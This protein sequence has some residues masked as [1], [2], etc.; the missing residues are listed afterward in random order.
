MQKKMIT[1]KNVKNLSGKVVTHYVPSKFEHTLDAQGTLTLLPA[2]IDPHVHFRTP[3]AEHKEDWMTAAKAAIHGGVTT[4]IDMPN[5]IPA[6]TTY[7]R[8]YE[9]K[10]R[11]ASQ[12]EQVKIPLRHYLYFGVDRNCL[13]EISRTK[14]EIIGLKIFMGSSTGE[15]LLDD[16]ISLEKAFAEAAK[17]NLLVAV[18]AEDEETLKKMKDRHPKATDPSFHS[19]IRCREAAIIA[20]TKAIK[21][22]EKYRVRLNVL[23]ISTKEEV[24]IIREA[25]LRG[26]T[27]FAETTPQH[28]FLTIDD[29]ALWGT[30]VQMNPPIRTQTDQD[31]LWK[32]LLD[33]TIDTIGTDHAPHTIAEKELPFG[34]APSGIPGIETVL[35]LLLD[36]YNKKRIT[37]E[38]IVQLTRYNIEAIFKLPMQDDVVLVDLNKT[39]TVQDENLKTKCGWSPFSGRQLTGW[40]VYT[41]VQG[42]IFSVDK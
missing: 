24:D 2:L 41:I 21:L 29:Y 36:A 7:E 39:K 11:I 6:C 34:K 17:N 19:I 14:N 26:I 12:L 22:A 15:L 9:K 33:G 40:P 5:T 23:H 27:V 28:L 31:A 1:I 3:G 35:P 20:V 25:K 30:K 18:H 4:V 32:G 13:N 10:A 16:D 37:L 8:L 38:R 42:Q